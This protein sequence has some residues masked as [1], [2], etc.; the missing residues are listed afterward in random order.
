L[1]REPKRRRCRR[2]PNLT[3]RVNTILE[4]AT[5]CKMRPFGPHVR[6]VSFRRRHYLSTAISTATAMGTVSIPRRPGIMTP[7]ARELDIDFRQ[8]GPAQLVDRY[9]LR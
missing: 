5:S 4:G 3:L 9:E 2:T 1:R 6:N 7:C 8:F